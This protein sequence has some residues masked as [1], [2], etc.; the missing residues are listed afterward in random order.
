M[1]AFIFKS[2]SFDEEE[3]TARFRYGF[4]SGESFEE[5]VTFQTG[6]EYDTALLDKALFLSFILVGVSYYKAFPSR[7]L[8]LPVPIDEWQATF[9]NSVYQEGLGQFAFENNLTRE[10]LAWFSGAG[11][12]PTADS[13]NGT[14]TLALQ[15]GGK[16]S[17]LVASLLDDFTPWYVANGD[18]HP[19]L[20]DSL[21]S[22]PLVISRR[23]VDIPSL[24]AAKEDGGLNGHVPI[25]YILSSLALVQAILLGKQHV[26]L[27]IAHEGE[28]PDAY[29]DDLAV[30]HQWSKTWK[31]EQALA[32][33][34][35]RY[36]SPELHIGSPLRSYSELCVAE[37]FV[38]HSW[39]KYGHVFSSCNVANYQQGNDNT[40]L[41][42]C[43]NCPK[44]ANSYLLFAPF[45]DADELGSLFGG[46][47]LFTS[48][49]LEETFKGLLGIDGV[50]KPFECIGEIDEL[51]RAYH[52]AQ[53]KGGYASLPF[54]VPDSS[55]DYL[56]AY[57]SQGW[58]TSMLQ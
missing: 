10:D 34:V 6:S 27:A 49:T 31:A 35:A 30:T 20:L 21:G 58:A 4:E 44:C 25:T 43:G 53:V 52:M 7:D 45:V 16:D 42:W 41:K 19:E 47:D 39:A 2:Y 36:I 1:S 14:G 26:L 8:V 22:D 56:Q 17:L 9:F 48:F 51:R 3:R 15:S 32:E 50:A 37:L 54:E 5:T 55:F 23:T 29:I 24:L 33:Y 40:N 12:Q 13:Y 38:E 57:P 18:Y 28:E 46:K 11:D